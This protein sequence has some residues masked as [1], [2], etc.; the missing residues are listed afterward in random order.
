MALLHHVC[1]ERLFALS[2]VT[3][4]H[5]FCVEGNIHS[6][7]LFHENCQIST[8]QTNFLPF[9]SHQYRHNY[10]HKSLFSGFPL[11]RGVGSWMKR[12]GWKQVRG[13]IKMTKIAENTPQS[14][15]TYFFSRKY[16][17]LFMLGMANL[18]RSRPSWGDCPQLNTELIRP[19]LSRC[20]NSARSPG[21][22]GKGGNYRWRHHGL[23]GV[24]D[25]FDTFLF[26][27]HFRTI[28]GILD[29]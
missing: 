28:R 2:H 25:K 1:K 10:E 21:H 14:Y 8:K 23:P 3:W 16:S 6:R 17:R 12:G 15:D 27:F 5:H 22:H 26:I 29:L 13:G 11:T 4:K 19:G 20:T 18:G 9:I 7:R 24:R